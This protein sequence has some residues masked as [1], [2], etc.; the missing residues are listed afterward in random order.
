MGM[1]LRNRSYLM[2]A[3]FMIGGSSQAG[4]QTLWAGPFLT[5]S[6]G[7]SVVEVGNALLWYSIGGMC[8]APLWGFLSDR[9][10]KSRKK[11]LVLTTVIAMILWA[12]PAFVPLLIPKWAVSGLL[13]IIGINW[14]AVILTHAMVRE[15]FSREILGTAVGIINF[16]TFLGSAFF[17]QLMGHMV[18]F[19]PRADGDYPLIA[20][21]STIMLIFGMWV[22]RLVALSFAEEKR[23]DSSAV[24]A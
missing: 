8:G 6:Y 12:L 21:Q 19:F 13:F 5:R 16:F 1:L 22:V 23:A 15:S 3:I 17:T 20:Y 10:F 14:G 11:V 9:L 7:F 18:E 24:Q 2:L 4:F